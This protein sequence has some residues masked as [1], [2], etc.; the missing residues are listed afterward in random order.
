M[1]FLCVCDVQSNNNL[2]RFSIDKKAKKKWRPVPDH[3]MSKLQIK[4]HK[5]R[6]YIS[7][8][9]D[10]GFLDDKKNPSFPTMM[11]IF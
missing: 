10:R 8:I 9:K 1:W 3:K 5:R 4:R 2:F 7:N 11:I 6:Y